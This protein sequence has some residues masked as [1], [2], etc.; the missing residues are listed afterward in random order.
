MTE[1][2]SAVGSGATGEPSWPLDCLDPG[3]E[4]EQAEAPPP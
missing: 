3:R 1:G 2:A 4:A